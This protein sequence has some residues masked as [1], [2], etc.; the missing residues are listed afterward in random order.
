MMKITIIDYDIS[1]ANILLQKLNEIGYDTEYASALEDIDTKNKSDIYLLSSD[2]AVEYYKKFIQT[3]QNKIII[4]LAS[5]YSDVTVRYPLDLGAKDYLVK[6]FRMEELERKIDY[7]RLKRSIE[8]YQSYIKYSLEKIDGDPK[9]LKHL[10]P[11]MIIHT[12]H[13]IFIDKLIMEYCQRKNKIFSFISLSSHNWKYKIRNTSYSN[14][15]YIS[16]LHLLDED[17]MNHLFKL[18]KN[19][20]FIISTTK[21]INTSYR[22]IKVN[23]DMQFYDGSYIIS[24]EEYIQYII[25]NFQD[26]ITDTELAKQ[27]EFSRK[28][29]YDRRNKYQIYKTKKRRM[30]S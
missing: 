12:N 10:K 22:M 25:K 8:S 4:V 13:T 17:E 24:I 2:Y 29:L 14:L 16:N 30:A 28:T 27:L 19:R 7:F 6:P 20:M 23:A 15:L 9:H 1:F 26:K 3:F 18:L 11:P 21:Y 5:T